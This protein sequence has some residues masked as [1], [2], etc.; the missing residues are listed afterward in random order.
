MLGVLVRGGFRPHDAAVTADTLQALAIGLVPFSVYLY[1]LR[2][3][4]ALQDTFTPFL[5]NA[6]ENG[7]NVVLARRAVP[8]ARRAGP[9]VGV[10]RRVHRRRGRRARRAPPPRSRT[11]ST[12]RSGCR[13]SA[14]WSG[15]VA[16]AIVAASLA[17]AIGHATANRALV[18]TAV[19]GLAGLRR[20]RRR[21]RRAAHAGARIARRTCSGGE[22]VAADISG[23]RT[24]APG[25]TCNHGRVRA[26]RN[27]PGPEEE[28]WPFAS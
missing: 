1:T 11:P 12:G 22:R 27:S 24:H 15:T 16:L 28:P 14:P 23:E 10:E 7:V 19:A 6:I 13:R 21:A 5:I 9:R 18:A 8:V 25:P 26:D 17:A 3:F 2:G 20:L 4:Y